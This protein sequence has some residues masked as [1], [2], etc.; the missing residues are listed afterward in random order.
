MKR[1]RTVWYEGNNSYSAALILRNRASWPLV[2]IRWAETCERRQRSERA[3]KQ[4]IQACQQH[5]PL[6]GVA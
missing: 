2:M 5:L 1:I 4:D 6:Q 3:T